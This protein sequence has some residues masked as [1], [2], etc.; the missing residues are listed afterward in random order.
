MPS[1]NVYN[2]YLA[3]LLRGHG[4]S[5]KRIYLKSSIFRSINS[6]H[7]VNCGKAAMQFIEIGVNLSDRMYQG[8]YNGS[9]KHESDLPSVLERA[10]KAGINYMII[11]GGSLS[12]AR[13]AIEMS[14][15][16][17]RLF[18]TVGCHP[19]RCNEFLKPANGDSNEASITNIVDDGSSYLNDLRQLIEH[20]KDKVVAI[21]EC[22]LDYDRL[23][24]C[25]KEIQLKYFE[26]Q[27]E[28]ASSTQLPLF[29][30]CRNAADDMAEIL[31][32]NRDKLPDKKGVVHSFDGSYED[33]KRFIELGFYIGIN[34]CSLKTDANIDV[35][36]QIPINKLMLETDAPWCEIRPTHASSKYIEDKSLNVPSVKKEKWKPGAMVKG[37]NEPC[38]IRQILDA[39]SGIK[40]QAEEPLTD[41]ILLA[42][43][44][45][46][47]TA[48]VFFSSK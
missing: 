42:E 46:R 47:N 24:F 29:L 9:K 39:V 45:Y 26:L 13:Q 8:E 36:R 7:K 32:R 41:K 16:D 34:G 20:N 14:K 15:L 43:E 2:I 17:D 12:D 33:A 27:L 48:N 30:H 31:E 21:G 22:G 3:S 5:G 6:L 38:N 28:L 19:T 23:K 1:I 35:V 18:A 25:P 11:T 37:R 4:T 10:W 44:I 40:S